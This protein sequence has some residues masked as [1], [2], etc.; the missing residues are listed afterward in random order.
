MSK[1][2]VFFKLELNLNTITVQLGYIKHL[3]VPLYE[4]TSH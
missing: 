4:F 2:L 1:I 3:S